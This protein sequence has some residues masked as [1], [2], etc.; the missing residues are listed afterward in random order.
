[1]KTFIASILIL[2]VI[3]APLNEFLTS[4]EE[5]TPEMLAQTTR[6]AKS[7]CAPTDTVCKRKDTYRHYE[8]CMK[9]PRCVAAVK[10]YYKNKAKCTSSKFC[11][12]YR[13]A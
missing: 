7:N 5:N 12:I 10:K 11:R 2:S 3:G 6:L 8:H 9:M 1:M 13:H 4:L